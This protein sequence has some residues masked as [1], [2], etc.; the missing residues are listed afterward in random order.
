MILVAE[1]NTIQG[2]MHYLA[3]NVQPPVAKVAV[4]V[5]VID[6]NGEP[7]GVIDYN[8]EVE[9]YCFYPQGVVR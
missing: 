8:R 3:A 5:K 1:L 7:L 6:S 4:E 2:L 9:A